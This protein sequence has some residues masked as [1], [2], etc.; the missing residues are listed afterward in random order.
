[1]EKKKTA[2]LHPELFTFYKRNNLLS[3]IVSLGSLYSN[4]RDNSSYISY[5]FFCNFWLIIFW[6][7]MKVLFL[8]LE[9]P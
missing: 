4:T 9:W 1:M 2:L 7:V 3:T 6:R 8:E 5:N